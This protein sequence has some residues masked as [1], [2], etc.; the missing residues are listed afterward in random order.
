MRQRGTIFIVLFILI[1]AAI[2]GASRFLGSQPPLEFT[3][4]V[5]PLAQTWLQESV[6][7]FNNTQPVVSTRRIVFTVTPIDDLDV[8][9]GQRRWTTDSHPDVWLPAS[10]VS[11]RYAQSNGLPVSD[12]AASLARTPLVWGGYA[13]RM[14]VLTSSGAR[15]F[16]WE[17]L[18][19]TLKNTQRWVDIGGQQDW[20]FIKLGFGQPRNKI[21]GLASLLSAAASYSANADLSQVV[22]SQQTFRDWLLPIIEAKPSFANAGITGDP[23]A[24]MT[25]GPSSIEIALFPETQWLLNL[26]G[27]NAQ[28]EIR[29]SYPAFQ[30]LLDFP[31]AAWNDASLPN[32]DRQAAVALLSSWLQTAEQQAKLMEYG[33]R[34][35]SSEPTVD[36]PLFKAGIPSGIQLNPVYGQ[37]I[38]APPLSETSGLIQWVET[39]GR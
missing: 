3:I 16:D 8:W 35:A 27:M 25:R 21:G 2:I 6:N 22:L 32:P 18:A 24:A 20:Q 36:N 28:E 17:L 38:T 14:D 5:D 9:Q 23:A 15:T 30:L 33:L 29:L 34:P 10:S 39:T 4:A 11:L 26:R 7:A 37:L 31:L 13:S 1:A 12:Q 19:G